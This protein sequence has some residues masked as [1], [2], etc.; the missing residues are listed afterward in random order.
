MRDA[1]DKELD[2]L[3]RMG[4][5]NPEHGVGPQLARRGARAAVGRCAADEHADLDEARGVLDADHDGLDD[6]KDRILEF[7]AVRVLRAR[8]RARPSVGGRGSGAILAL[9]GPPGVGKTSLG[10]SVA[11]RWAARS[12]A[13]P[14]A[15][16]A[17]RP[18]SVVTGVPTSA[19]GP[20]ASC[21]R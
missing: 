15:V 2:Q 8:A 1:V 5:Q 6:V 20:D 10:E 16:C 12:S 21:A 3:E 17:T 18:R 11:R 4:E 13:S 7:L 19:R 9:V 14:S